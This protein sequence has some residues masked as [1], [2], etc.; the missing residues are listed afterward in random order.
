M[1]CRQSRAQA[2][3]LHT[4]LNGNR[5]TG[6]LVKTKQPGQAVAQPK[7]TYVQQQ[8]RGNQYTLVIHDRFPILRENVPNDQNNEYHRN[9]W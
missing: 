4:H 7:P 6:L 8:D 1:L 5:P 2:A 3:V 9:K